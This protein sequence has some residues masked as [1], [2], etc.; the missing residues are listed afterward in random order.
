MRHDGPMKRALLVIDVQES[1]RQRPLWQ[2]MSNPELFSN[3]SALIDATRQSG[4]MV[5]WVLHNEPGT[6]GLFDS[7]NGLVKVMPELQYRKEELVVM[8]TAH[9]SFSTT[10]LQQQLQLAGVREIVITGIRTEQCCETTARVGSDYGYQTTFVTDATATFVTPHWSA[11]AGQSMTEIIA[12][13]KSLSGADMTA[14]TEYALAGR[15]AQIVTTR[16]LVGV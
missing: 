13:P 7:V 5:V 4:D 1:F 10:N 8:K 16:E 6:G 15:F 3:I 9:N 12:D 11:P 14:R 2:T